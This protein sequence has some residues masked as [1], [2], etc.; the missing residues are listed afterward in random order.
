MR[1]TE[2]HTSI[3]VFIVFLGAI[4]GN[5]VGEVLG[6]NIKALSFLKTLYT[7][8]TAQPFNLNLKV[9][10]IIFGF[11]FNF[12]LMSIIGII[13]AIILIRKI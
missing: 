2:R 11:N 4:T 1:N 7:I 5:V 10:S 13:V 6:S 8:G 3:F 9:I 12:N